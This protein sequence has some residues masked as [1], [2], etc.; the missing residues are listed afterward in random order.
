MP[1]TLYLV[2][3]PIGN[4]ED[5]T[6]RAVRV[7]REV[8]LI[9]AEDT[10]RTRVLLDRYGCATPATSLHEHNEY[11]KAPAL[12]ARLL[13]GAS[14]A[15]VADAGT[16]VVSD[17]GLL[18][19]RQAH[20]AGVPVVPVPGPSAVVAALVA[21]G[22]P[23]ASFT[24]LGFPPRKLRDREQWCRSVCDSAHTVLF[25]EAPHRLLTT[26]RLLLEIA[27]DR[28]LALGRELTKAHEELVIGPM[29]EVLP[30][31]G[32]PRGEYTGVL[33]PAESAT[34]DTTGLPSPTDLARE[35]RTVAPQHPSRRAAIKSLA[36]KYGVGS[37]EIY[38]CVERGKL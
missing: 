35:L 19:V 38:E 29:S 33:W 13:S 24:F 18:L 21:S 23:P 3:T 5:I 36:E 9:A 11:R 17:P 2:A 27:G 34:P 15:L 10:R 30:R 37:R 4:L 8:D 28:R 26:L 6:Y 25:F 1:G 31:V 12:V 16:P 14:V 22:A 20:D 7:L 32:T